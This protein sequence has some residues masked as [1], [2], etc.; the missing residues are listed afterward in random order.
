MDGQLTPQL[1]SLSQ[2]VLVRI[3]DGKKI[4]TIASEL[5]TTRDIVDGQLRRI[6]RHFSVKGIALLVHAAI[7]EG[8]IEHPAGTNA[9]RGSE[10]KSAFAQR[11]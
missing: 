11:G 3:T 9:Q 5:G 8:W 4:E 7:R 10:E 2:Q 1:S 6:Y